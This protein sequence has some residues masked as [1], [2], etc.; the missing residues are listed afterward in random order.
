MLEG[1]EY[2]H[3]FLGGTISVV[4]EP[5]AEKKPEYCIQWENSEYEFHIHFHINRP[6]TVHDVLVAACQQVIERYQAYSL[7]CF[8]EDGHR[9]HAIH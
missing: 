4:E 5:N 6:H 7:Q 1:K 8:Q 2:R 9:G 3:T